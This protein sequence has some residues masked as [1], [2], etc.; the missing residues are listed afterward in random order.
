MEINVARF[1]R[2]IKKFSNTVL[3]VF[4]MHAHSKSID[5]GF[6]FGK[7]VKQFLQYISHPTQSSTTK[8]ATS[9]VQHNNALKLS[10]SA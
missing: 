5:F 6:S 9:Q 4:K 1:A 3:K 10:L 2:I 7:E 8:H